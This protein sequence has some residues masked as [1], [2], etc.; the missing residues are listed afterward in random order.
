M[1]LLLTYISISLSQ[2]FEKSI[3]EFN[4]SDIFDDLGT[5]E[6][7]FFLVLYSSD[8]GCSK[9]EYSNRS[10][11]EKTS[12]LFI[13]RINFLTLFNTHFYDVILCSCIIICKCINID[14]N[15]IYLWKYF[16]ILR[17]NVLRVM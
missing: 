4:L 16:N 15:L 14:K 3:F 9:S 2:D 1:F 11:G 6:V 17:L 10:S 5:W 7:I 13:L 8:W 12:F